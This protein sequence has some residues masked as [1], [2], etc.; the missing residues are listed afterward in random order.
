MTVQGPR[1]VLILSIE[2]NILLT[3]SR[4]AITLFNFNQFS[5][6]ITPNEQNRNVATQF[7]YVYQTKKCVN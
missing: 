2:L 7:C 5:P 1:F 4:A 3:I 6:F